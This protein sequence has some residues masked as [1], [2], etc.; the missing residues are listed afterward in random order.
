MGKLN[1]GRL[2]I[3]RDEFIE[4]SFVAASSVGVFARVNRIGE[5]WCVWL[6][7]KHLQKSFPKIKDALADIEK[8]FIAWH[9][10]KN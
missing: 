4:N 9:R 2:G 1:E 7:K 8:E 5:R 6:Y 3:F 10:E